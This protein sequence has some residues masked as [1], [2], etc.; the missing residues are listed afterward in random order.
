MLFNNS[1]RFSVILV[2][3]CKLL[4]LENQFLYLFPIHYGLIHLENTIKMNW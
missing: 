2:V 1:F 4:V 3:L